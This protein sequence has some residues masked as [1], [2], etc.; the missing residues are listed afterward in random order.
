MN[1]SLFDMCIVPQRVEELE[2]EV[3]DSKETKMAASSDAAA[4]KV[5]IQPY[6]YIC[7]YS[8][9]GIHIYKHMYIYVYMAL[10]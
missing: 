8:S 5:Y 9:A 7:I 2:G 10:Q 1:R 6:E 4:L 3:A